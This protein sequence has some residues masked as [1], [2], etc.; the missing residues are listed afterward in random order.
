MM[1]RPPNQNAK[2]GIDMRVYVTAGTNLIDY[3]EES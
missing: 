2:Q 1:S 3:R